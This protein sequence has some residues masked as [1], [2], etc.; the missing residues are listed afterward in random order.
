MGGLATRAT[1]NGLSVKDAKAAELC[2]KSWQGICRV[3]GWIGV[4]P[5]LVEVFQKVGRDFLG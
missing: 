4:V 2:L 3:K 1:N 5:L